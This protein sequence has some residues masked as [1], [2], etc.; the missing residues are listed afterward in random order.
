MSVSFGMF[1]D[2]LGK[3]ILQTGLFQPFLEPSYL[4]K[5]AVKSNALIARRVL[6]NI[7]PLLPGML[8]AVHKKVGFKITRSQAYT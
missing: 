6:L 5:I 1:V 7:S 2:I 4:S 8:C 3:S